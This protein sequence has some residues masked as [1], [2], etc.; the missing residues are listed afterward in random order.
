MKMLLGTE[1]KNISQFALDAAE[2]PSL[3]QWLFVWVALQGYSLME[4][5]LLFRS[6][7]WLNE[8]QELVL[9][10]MYLYPLG[11]KTETLHTEAS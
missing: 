9:S 5:K 8:A 3:S 1:E 6:V 10:P 4:L 11:K 2:E 7:L